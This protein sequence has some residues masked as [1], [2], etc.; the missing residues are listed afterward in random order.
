[1]QPYTGQHCRH[2][3]HSSVG[4]IAEQTVLTTRKLLGLVLDLKSYQIFVKVE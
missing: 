1:M 2:N 3:L 4:L